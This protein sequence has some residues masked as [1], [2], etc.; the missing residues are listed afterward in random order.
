[1]RRKLV[2]RTLFILSDI[3]LVVDIEDSRFLS[4]L[5]QITKAKCVLS[6]WHVYQAN[7]CEFIVVIV[8]SLSSYITIAEFYGIQKLSRM[9][10]YRSNL[11]APEVGINL[12]LLDPRDIVDYNWNWYTTCAP[13][14]KSTIPDMDHLCL[15]FPSHS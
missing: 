13:A 3:L 5:T 15:E 6:I 14:L 11:L 12:T 4:G 2:E 1:M 8:V 7:C 10:I 9:V